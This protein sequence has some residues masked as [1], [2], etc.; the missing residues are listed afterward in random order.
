MVVHLLPVTSFGWTLTESDAAE[1]ALP[2]V[3]VDVTDRPDVADLARVHALDG[4]GDVRTLATEHR[5]GIRLDVVLNSPVR[6]HFAFVVPHTARDIL[7]AA[8]A[9]GQLVIATGDP[10]VHGTTWLAV[11]I[12]ADAF[13]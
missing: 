13:D 9:V 2:T 8:A 5:D 12:D 1:R 4:T 10:S 3:A 7:D 6:C 11:F